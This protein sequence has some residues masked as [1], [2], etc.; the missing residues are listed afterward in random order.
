MARRRKEYDIE[1]EIAR[2]QLL[3]EQAAFARRC[4]TRVPCPDALNNRVMRGRSW[5]YETVAHLNDG[6]YAR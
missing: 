1:A 5:R 6:R 4:T 3:S 2:A